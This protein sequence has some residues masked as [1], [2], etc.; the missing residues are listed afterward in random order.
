VPQVLKVLLL[1]VA[2]QLALLL[3]GLAQ[4]KAFHKV[5]RHAMVQKVVQTYATNLLLALVIS[6]LPVLS[7][8]T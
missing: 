4:L 6:M 8:A 1:L 3:F 7:V 5:G 2:H